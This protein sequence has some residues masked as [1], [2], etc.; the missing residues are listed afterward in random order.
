[1]PVFV[2]LERELAYRG[3]LYNSEEK[4]VSATRNTIESLVQVRKVLTSPPMC[5]APLRAEPNHEYFDF[6]AT[7]ALHTY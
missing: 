4:H 3:L 1:M 2:D 6:R 7:K 5:R